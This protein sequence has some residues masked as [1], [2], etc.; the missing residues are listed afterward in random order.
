MIHSKHTALLGT[1]YWMAPEVITSGSLYDSKV[2]VGS[3]GDTLYQM[4]IGFLL[5]S[6]QGDRYSFQ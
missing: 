6:N 2:D 4:A 3:L 1:L 5:H